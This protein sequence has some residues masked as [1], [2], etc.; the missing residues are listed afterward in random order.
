MTALLAP[1][2]LAL[3]AGLLAAGAGYPLLGCRPALRRV[4]LVALALLVLPAPLLVPL[5]H[6]AAAPVRWLIAV[7]GAVI[8]FKLYDLHRGLLPHGSGQER[9]RTPIP[10]PATYAGHMLV[11]TFWSLSFRRR[12]AHPSPPRLAGRAA[13][14][15]AG[16]FLGGGAWALQRTVL[17]LGRVGFLLDHTA[18][19]VA[20]GVA[21]AGFMNLAALA[22]AG[23][24]GRPTLLPFDAPL[25]A[26]TPAAFW[27]RWNRAVSDY[28]LVNVARPAGGREHPARGVLAAF[29]VS[30]LLHEYVFSVALGVVQGYQLAFFLLHGLAV[31]LTARLDPRGP[32]Q[33]L[34]LLGTWSLLLASSILFFASLAGLTAAWFPLYPHGGWLP[35]AGLSA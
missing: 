9:R 16:L 25:L 3:A 17:D 20:L 11:L 32:R 19:A 13:W 15:A 27:R 26:P 28:L 18:Q 8:L 21:V 4:G 24:T 5:G 6:P 30:A 23:L 33:V 1:A 14:A 7:H 34:G 12:A 2:L 35:V 22:R 31:V 10:P 29:L